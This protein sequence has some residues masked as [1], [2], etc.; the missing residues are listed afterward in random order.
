M[1]GT[2]MTVSSSRWMAVK[3]LAAGAGHQRVWL[4]GR[5]PLA[6]LPHGI[7]LFRPLLLVTPGLEIGLGPLR[8][9][10]APSGLEVGPGLVEGRGR[11]GGAL[12]GVS[13]RIEPA[14]PAPRGL[15]ARDPDALADRADPDVAI[16]YLSAFL[17]TDR[18]PHRLYVSGSSVMVFQ[19]LTHRIETSR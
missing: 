19:C 3:R 16:E 1:C 13:A 15:V 7:F 9:E 12:T 4:L 18:R 6:A 11:A 17:C 14:R 5:Q 8:Q 2:W 10:D